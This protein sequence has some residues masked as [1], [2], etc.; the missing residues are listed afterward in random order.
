MLVA[1]E[2]DPFAAQFCGGALIHPEWVLTA[3][4]CVSGALPGDID[5]VLEESDLDAIT[6]GDRRDISEIDIHPTY[7]SSTKEFDLALL[8]LTS[9]ARRRPDR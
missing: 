4:H 5:V 7:N 6:A 2:S 1:S 3:A 8:K 9:P